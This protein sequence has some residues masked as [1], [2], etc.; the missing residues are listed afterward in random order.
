MRCS[1]CN[2]PLTV[3]KKCQIGCPICDG[4]TKKIVLTLHKFNDFSFYKVIG[5]T[6]IVV[7]SYLMPEELD[8]FIKRGVDITTK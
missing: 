1:I 3:N 8:A 5:F 2:G 7:D 4:G 6:N